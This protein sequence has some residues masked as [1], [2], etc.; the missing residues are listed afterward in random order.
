MRRIGNRAQDSGQVVSKLEDVAAIEAKKLFGVAGGM[1]PF[2]ELAAAVPAWSD[3]LCASAASF[4]ARCR[5]H[6]RMTVY[7]RHIFIDIRPR[8]RYRHNARSF[9]GRHR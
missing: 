4:E 9:E 8:L 7:I 6:L 1:I 5:L 2:P 3:G